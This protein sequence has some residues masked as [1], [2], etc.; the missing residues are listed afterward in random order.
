MTQRQRK[1]DDEILRALTVLEDADVTEADAAFQ[2]L[3][4]R[5]PKPSPRPGFAAR[6]MYAVQQAPLPAGRVA[7]EARPSLPLL[8]GAAALAGVAA[9]WVAFLLAPVALPI[10]ARVFTF[11]VQACLLFIPPL[12]AGLDFW[13][14]ISTI[15]RALSEAATSPEMLTVL[16]AITSVGALSFGALTRLLS[17]QEESPH[18]ITSLC[19]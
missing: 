17:S 8:V 2:A 6:V 1:K 14:L 7:L 4:R 5:L 11:A 16:A 18:G 19:I 10:F 12:T 13:A 9:L 3:A 15:A